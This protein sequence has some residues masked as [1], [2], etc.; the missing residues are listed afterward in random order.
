MANNKPPTSIAEMMSGSHGQFSRPDGISTR[1]IV[2]ERAAYAPM[3]KLGKYDVGLTP[4]IY[5]T[6][7]FANPRLAQQYYRADNQSAGKQLWNGFRSRALSIPLKVGEGF[8][9]LI[10]AVDAAAHGDMDRMYDNA[11]VGLFSDLDNKIKEALPVYQSKAYTEGSWV[12]KL[13][14]TSF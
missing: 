12:R 14:T 4:A 6:A 7:S 2:A 1:N 8:G 9:Y 3:S 11:I 10:G 13:G 5:E